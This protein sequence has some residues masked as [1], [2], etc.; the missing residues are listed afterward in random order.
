MYFTYIWCLCIIIFTL[1]EVATSVSLVCIW[2]MFGS[3]ISAIISFWVDDFAI[4]V[5]MFLVSSLISLIVFR[6]YVFSKITATNRT[7]NS[8]VG[9]K[10]IVHDVVGC[11]GRTTVNGVSWLVESLGCEDLVADTVYEVV[12]VKGTKLI[13]IKCS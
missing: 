1:L 6:K 10:V 2:F 7:F 9:K 4:Q 3:L 12:E 8:H 5:I 13:V 11:I